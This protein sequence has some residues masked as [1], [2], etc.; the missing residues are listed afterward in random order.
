MKAFEDQLMKFE[1]TRSD[2]K[3]RIKLSDL[4]YLVKNS[5]NNDPDNPI[6]I[7][8]HRNIQAAEA[9]VKAL[10]DDDPMS[11]D[12]RW[13]KMLEEIFDEWF[14]GDEDFLKYPEWR[15]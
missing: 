10:M 1:V 15:W 2:L 13:G 7:K 5:I 9:L 6:K 14:S 3:M 12:P 11:G 4:E 8:P